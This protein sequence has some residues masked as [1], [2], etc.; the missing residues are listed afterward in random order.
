MPDEVKPI[1]V[2][3][4]CK[5]PR[6]PSL[7]GVVH[8]TELAPGGRRIWLPPAQIDKEVSNAQRKRERKAERKTQPEQRRPQAIWSR[9]Q[10]K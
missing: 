3:L 10:R 7:A 2:N 1:V 9:V 4:L 8:V 6:P 5:E